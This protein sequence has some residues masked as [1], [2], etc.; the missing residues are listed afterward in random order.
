MRQRSLCAVLSAA[1]PEGHS[2]VWSSGDPSMRRWHDGRSSRHQGAHAPAKSEKRG[3]T[4]RRNHARIGSEVDR[5][6]PPCR[7]TGGKVS[8]VGPIP[9][10]RE[11]RPVD[12]QHRRCGASST[13]RHRTVRCVTSMPGG[14]CRSASSTADPREAMQALRGLRDD[15]A[16]PGLTI[17]AVR[18]GRG[19]WHLRN[20]EVAEGRAAPG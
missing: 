16:T 18:A 2:S 19:R 1:R 14:C 20:A 13:P 3:W 9:P 7:R 17:D 6:P 15:V 8:S 10:P 11:A 12:G 5:T 4:C